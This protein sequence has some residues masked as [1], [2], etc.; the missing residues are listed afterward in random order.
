[1]RKSIKTV[2]IVSLSAIFALIITTNKN[3]SDQNPKPLSANADAGDWCAPHPHLTCDL[4][5]NT[6]MHYKLWEN[7]QELTR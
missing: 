3:K 1:M 5:G 6:Y 2:L 4:A 7:E